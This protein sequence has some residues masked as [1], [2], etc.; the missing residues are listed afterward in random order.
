MHAADEKVDLETLPRAGGLLPRRAARRR[1]AAIGGDRHDAGNR[2]YLGSDLLV[3]WF[4][5]PCVRGGSRELAELA[6]AY[7]AR[8]DELAEDPEAFD[9]DELVRL[10][11]MEERM[12]VLGADLHK[13]TS[14]PSGRRGRR[15]GAGVHGQAQRRL[16]AA[17][18]PFARVP[19]DRGARADRGR[20][21]APSR[22]RRVPFPHRADERARPSYAL[23]R[24]G[25][26][27]RARSALRR[28]GLGGSAQRAGVVRRDR[29][30]RQQRSLT[31]LRNFATSADAALRKRAF[32]AEI[33]CS[34]SIEQ[35]MSFC[36]N[37]IKAQESL[38]AQMR[39]YESVLDLTMAQ[40]H[41]KGPPR[42]TR[43]GRRCARICR[44][45]T[46]TCAKRRR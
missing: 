13:F 41:M 42:S 22:A 33:E 15:G 24:G 14:R 6:D 29:A 18:F 30:R 16:R 28:A 3:R 20:L 21:R 36:L 1:R 5:R 46:P 12:W 26:P 7:A 11:E 34:R 19:L 35:G 31:E 8:V 32:D 45:S 4:R 37:G 17:R 23:A 38:E 2:S 27:V 10:L 25:G 40:S 44:C 39:G 9:A 43:C